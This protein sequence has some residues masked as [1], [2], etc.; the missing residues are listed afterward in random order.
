MAEEKVQGMPATS[1]EKALRLLLLLGDEGLVTVS[2]AG[3]TLGIAR[4]T[5][6]RLLT[7][8]QSYGF[9][10]QDPVTKAYRPG[11]AL[12]MAGLSAVGNLDTRIARPYLEELSAELGETI[13]L[14]V[15]SGTKTLVV[16]SVESVQS[17]RVTAR[18]GGSLPPHLTS[19]GKVLLSQLPE[20]RVRAIVGPDPLPTRTSASID[21]LA[22]LRVEL[23]RVR[24]QGYALNLS[25][26]EEGIVAVA[27]GI[28]SKRADRP[29]AI[30]VAMPELRFNEERLPELLAVSRRIVGEIA[31]RI[32]GVQKLALA[33]VGA[34]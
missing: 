28:P 26:N 13:H 11:R 14:V 25:E 1:V 7:A 21:N 32:D 34:A 29:A 5:A 3:A 23:E 22:A 15:L 4:S 2:H 27:V 30:A 18:L 12:L 19:A 17:L 33:D 9:A 8:L 16:D 6:H 31:A 20:E 24:E 10:E